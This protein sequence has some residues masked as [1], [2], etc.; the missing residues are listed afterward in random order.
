MK[1]LYCIPIISI[2]DTKTDGT[3]YQYDIPFRM[4][5]AQSLNCTQQTAS[6]NIPADDDPDFCTMT[7]DNGYDCSLQLTCVPPEFDRKILKNKNGIENAETK[8][9]AFALIAEFDGDQKKGRHLFWHCELT[10]RPDVT[11]TTKDNN[12]TIDS[13]TINFKAVKRKDTGDIKAKVYEDWSVYNTMFTKVPLPSEII[14]PD[15]TAISIS[16]EDSVKVK[17]KITLTAET[18]PSGTGVTWTSLDT[19]NATVTGGVVTGVAAGTATIKAALTSDDT[20]FA[21]KV[22]T[23][24]AEE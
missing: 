1:N 13:E 17:G 21:T 7:Q 11:G 24:T 15:E 4:I 14:D 18:Q 3:G 22:I 8:P 10:K 23:I 5:G 6:Q 2:D 12:L 9:A 20:V 19:D 16:G